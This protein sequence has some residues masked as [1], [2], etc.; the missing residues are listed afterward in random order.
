MKTCFGFMFWGVL[1]VAI[2]FKF[3]QFDFVPDFVGG[4]GY[5]LVAIGTGGLATMT[6]NFIAACTFG[7]LLV[8]VTAGEAYLTGDAARSFAVLMTVMNFAMMWTTLSGVQDIAI[9]RNRPELARQCRPAPGLPRSLAVSLGLEV[10]VNDTASAVG[11]LTGM[12]VMSAVVV[13]AFILRFLYR[14]W[15]KLGP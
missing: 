12:V 5:A 4:L 14:A 13:F 15:G 9:G 8:L 2:D 11:L 3:K 7:W 10:F 6:G 1:L